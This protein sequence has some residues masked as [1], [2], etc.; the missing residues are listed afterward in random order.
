MKNK[1]VVKT[2]K[3]RQK[4]A[5][6]KFQKDAAKMAEQGYYPTTQAWAEGAYGCG[7]FIVALLLCFILVGI[8]IFILMIVVKPPGTLTVTYQLKED[9]P[10]PVYIQ[11]PATPAPPL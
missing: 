8:I 2:Y 11:A 3:G 9:S 5:N 7:D 1:V 4:V 6:A 10:A